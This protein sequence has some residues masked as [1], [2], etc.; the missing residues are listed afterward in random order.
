VEVFRREERNGPNICQNAETQASADAAFSGPSLK[1][2]QH[3]VS[4][5]LSFVDFQI[6]DSQNVDFQIVDSEM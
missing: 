6:T 1:R 2:G 3:V 4:V 5:P